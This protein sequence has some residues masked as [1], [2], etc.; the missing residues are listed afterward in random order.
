MEADLVVGQVVDEKGDSMSASDGI[1]A[2]VQS[3]ITN[4][5]GLNEQV[6]IS[7][8]AAGTCTAPDGTVAQ[9]A[10]RAIPDA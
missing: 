9:L 2:A 10:L 3:L 7:F 6:P 8:G 5:G 1:N 4:P